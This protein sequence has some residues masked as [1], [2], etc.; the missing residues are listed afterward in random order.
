MTGR[1]VLRSFHSVKGGVGKS[2]LATVSAIQLAHAHPEAR[3][4]LI[5]M[6]LTGTSLADV[7][8]LRAP[9]WKEPADPVRLESEPD[10]DLLSVE[11]SRKGIRRRED[12]DQDPYLRHV[13]FLNDYL[14]Y[15]PPDGQTDADPR[16]LFWRLASAPENLAVVPSSALPRDLQR[17]LPVIFDEHQSA[18]LE[19][20]LE[21]L[22]AR[23]LRIDEDEDTQ[24]LRDLC[25]VI[26]VPPTLPGLS[27]AVLSVVLRLTAPDHVAALVDDGQSPPVFKQLGERD[28]MSFVVASEDFQD[29]RA[30]ARWLRLAD[31][32]R[33]RLIVNR[34]P[35][36]GEDALRDYLQD[37]FGGG[38]S[39]A[40]G[41]ARADDWAPQFRNAIWIGDRTDFVF[42]RTD[43]GPSVTTAPFSWLEEP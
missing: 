13:P 36:Q 16:G 40:A 21:A 43:E 23:V 4:L 28:G 15:A 5:D 29:L 25:V 22:I 19:A 20:R 27:R 24:E 11:A 12:C 31:D 3:V 17:I 42:F 10:A 32:P 8:P 14:L 30:A 9:S 41:N 26:D 35:A 37:Q 1:L 38:A 6:D 34:S 2:T 39:L 18:F 33:L 7:L